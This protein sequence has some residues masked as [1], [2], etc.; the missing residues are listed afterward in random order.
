[1]GG[2]GG[3]GGGGVGRGNLLEIPKWSHIDRI[4][5]QSFLDSHEAVH[6]TVTARHRSSA[7]LIKSGR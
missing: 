7:P 5:S 4:E 2:G 1:M 6:S 3:G